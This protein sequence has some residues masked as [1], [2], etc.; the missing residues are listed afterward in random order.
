MIHAS[1]TLTWMVLAQRNLH[2]CRK[3]ILRTLSTPLGTD[4]AS[5]TTTVSCI[6][7]AWSPIGA[8]L[9]GA[10][11]SCAGESSHTVNSNYEGGANK[12]T[13]IDSQLAD[14]HIQSWNFIV[15]N[16]LD[17]LLPLNLWR[18]S[19]QPPIV[20]LT[21]FTILKNPFN[22][23]C[24]LMWIPFKLISNSCSQLTKHRPQIEYQR[25]HLHSNKIDIAKPI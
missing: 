19:E 20:N 10:G 23:D 3:N 1:T 4:S 16:R 6:C 14:N 8:G 24:F 9:W 11:I 18:N 21:Q 7:V 5:G 22:W 15:L 12:W 25:D 13:W 17:E 2:R